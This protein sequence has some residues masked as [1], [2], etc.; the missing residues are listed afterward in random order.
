MTIDNFIAVNRPGAQVCQGEDGSAAC[1][2]PGDGG[3]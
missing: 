2:E 1:V 3:A